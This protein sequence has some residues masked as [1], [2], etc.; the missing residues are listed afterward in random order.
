[1]N[2]LISTR[3]IFFLVCLS[4]VFFIWIAIMHFFKVPSMNVV[5][6]T[7]DG[8]NK[9]FSIN[10]DNLIT[11]KGPLGDTVIQIKNKKVRIIKSSCPNHI[12]IKS[13]WISSTHDALICLPNKIIVKISGENK[14][15]INNEIDARSF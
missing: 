8:Y 3:D 9:I 15:E 7:N 14:E 4:V 5:I 2:K 11:V 13:G 12:C 6:E 10:K 1:M